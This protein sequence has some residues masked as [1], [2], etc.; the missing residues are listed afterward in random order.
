MADIA[1][2][3]RD[4]IAEVRDEDLDSLKRQAEQILDEVNKIEDLISA[5]SKELVAKADD[6]Y[7]RLSDAYC[8]LRDRCRALPEIEPPRVAG[9]LDLIALAER[10]AA[11]TDE[12]WQ[13]VIDLAMA[14][15]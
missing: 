11:L 2:L 6:T 7:Y 8:S 12:Q 13:R 1:K 14:L 10:C 4:E 9:L 5:V 15:K 3:L